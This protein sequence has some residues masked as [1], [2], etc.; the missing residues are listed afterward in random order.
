MTGIDLSEES[1]KVCKSVGKEKLKLDMRENVEFKCC[2][3]EE[4]AYM[5][6]KKYDVIIASE[7]VEH[8][9]ELNFFMK[10]CSD[11]SV[12]NNELKICNK[13]RKMGIYL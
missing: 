10:A 8:V 6:E 2:S 13:N 4:L 3:V 9:D 5:K 7:V 1:I 12:V 11:L